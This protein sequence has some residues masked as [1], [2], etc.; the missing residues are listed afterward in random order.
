MKKWCLLVTAALMAITGGTVQA[1]GSNPTVSKKT[2]TYS[3]QQGRTLKVTYGFNK[4]GLPTYAAASLNGRKRVLPIN[5]ARSDIAGTM[6]GKENGYVVSTG[7]LDSK[8]YRTSSAMVTSPN[9]QILYKGCE[10]RR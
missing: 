8:N 10:T 3:C 1:A 6:F 2:V 9:N 4:Q 5:L 7:Y